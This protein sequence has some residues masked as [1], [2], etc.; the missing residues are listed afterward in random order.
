M[1]ARNHFEV[2]GGFESS[3]KEVGQ[4]KAFEVRLEGLDETNHHS[5]C[6]AV[7][8][9]KCFPCLGLHENL[10]SRVIRS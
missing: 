4:A 10:W 7:E 6:G 9:T 1:K 2:G 8:V 5:S 3:A